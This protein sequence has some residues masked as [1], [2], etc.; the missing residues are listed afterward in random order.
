MACKSYDKMLA[1][2]LYLKYI[3][4]DKAM[5]EQEKLDFLEDVM[6]MEEGTLSADMILSDIEEWDSLSRLALLAEVKKQFGKKLTADEIK[7]FKTVKDICD[8]LG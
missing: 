3:K 1:N 7:A 5:T 2:K 4:G 6:E 8:Y